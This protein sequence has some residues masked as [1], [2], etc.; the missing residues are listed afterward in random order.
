M[1]CSVGCRH[2]SDLGS[3]CGCGV[4]QQ[5]QLQF[6]NGHLAWEHPYTTPVALKEKKEREK[7]K[8]RNVAQRFGE[9]ATQLPYTY[10]YVVSLSASHP[11]FY[12]SKQ[13]VWKNKFKFKKPLKSYILSI[14]RIDLYF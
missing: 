8:R 10:V 3:C 13:S 2:S 11:R 9:E 6:S 7:K 1:S 14:R 12:F 5:L 4:G